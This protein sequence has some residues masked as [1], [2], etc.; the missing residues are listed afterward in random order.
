MYL[1]GFLMT[2]QPTPSASMHYGRPGMS[3]V[4]KRKGLLRPDHHLFARDE[5]MDGAAP[6]IDVRK[7][8]L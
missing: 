2:V 8:G 7:G 4:Q 1:I 5:G 6:L 3:Q